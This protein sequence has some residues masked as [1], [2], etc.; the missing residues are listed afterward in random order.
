MPHPEQGHE[1]AIQRAYYARTAGMYDDMH[2]GEESE[3]SFALA[4]LL[5]AVDLL[6]VTSVLDIGSGTGRVLVR[7]KERRPDIVVV[8]V[9]PSIE[10][11]QIGHKKGL[12]ESELVAGDATALEYTDQ[13]FDLVCEF[14]ALHHIPRPDRAVA[15]MLRVARKAV[16]ISDSNNFG[17]GSPVARKLKQVINALGM[18][19]IADYF[20][21]KGKGYT[22]TEGDGVA[23]SYS[24]FN[25][26]AFVKSKCKSVHL[27]NTSN[28]GP[29]LYRNAPHIALLGIK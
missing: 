4:Y 19:P 18:W 8:G 6:G 29:D 25:D 20:K 13:S 28:A 11:R 3:H 9:E 10:L 24:V 14:G 17:Q 23:Y 15:E 26:F 1:V 22:F 7:L 27:L 5:V 21:T 2:V 12:K 16:F